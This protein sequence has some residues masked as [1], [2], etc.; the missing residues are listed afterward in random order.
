[1][2]RYADD[3]VLDRVYESTPKA[4]QKN[5]ASVNDW[6]RDIKREIDG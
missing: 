1:M 3:A 2:T 6:Y 5:V 4:I